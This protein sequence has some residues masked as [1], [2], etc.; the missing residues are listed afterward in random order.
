LIPGSSA[1]TKGPR[2]TTQERVRMTLIVVM[3]GL[4]KA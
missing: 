1:G 2:M 4:D 3:A